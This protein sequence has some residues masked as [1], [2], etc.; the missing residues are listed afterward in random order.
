MVAGS[1][2]IEMELLLSAM[3]IWIAIDGA[4]VLI[5]LQQTGANDQ[6]LRASILLW[7]LGLGCGLFAVALPNDPGST[8]AVFA[9]AFVNAAM[10]LQ[11][12]SHQM[13]KI[14]VVLAATGTAGGLV[15]WLIGASLALPVISAAG[16]ACLG[17]VLISSAKSYSRR[18]LRDQNVRIQA[19]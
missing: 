5:C 1:S 6:R 2:V 11:P 13:T 18:G 16:V 12:K 10:S 3:A 19:R 9:L 14:L 15:L 4:I 8:F 7:L 17:A